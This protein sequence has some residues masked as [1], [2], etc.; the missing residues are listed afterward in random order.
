[1]GSVTFSLQYKGFDYVAFFNGAYEDSNSLASLLQTGANS[2]EA[3][4]D[5]GIDVKT[6]Q[7]VA[8][9]NYTDS[10]TAMGST[11]DQAEGL[12]LSVMVRP[13]IDF[14]NPAVIGPYSVGDWR[15][16]YQPTN[17]SAFFASYKQMI[18]AEAQVAQQHGAQ[19]LSIGAELD[20]L[21]GAQYL[22]YWTDIISSVRAVF[23][24]QLTYS[25]SWNTASNVSFWSQ[26]NY[27][28]I[29]CY[30]PLS[31]AQN[32]TLQDLVNGWIEPATQSANPG[33]YAVIGNQSPIQYFESLAAQSGK[34]LLFT[35][36]GYANDSGAAANPSASG[37]SPDPTLQAELY[38][39]FFQA[40]A[41]SGSSSLIG[42]YFWEWDPNGNTSNVGPGIDSFSP[43]N[44]PAQNEVTAGFET[45][46]GNGHT[47]IVS[48][49]HTLYA[50]TVQSGG[51]EIVNS[52]G[53]AIGSTISSGAFQVIA[54]GGTA[55]DAVMNGAAT[56]SGGSLELTSGAFAGGPVTFAGMSGT[57]RID[58]TAMPS[59]VI[60]GFARGDTIDLAGASFASGGS[61][62]LKS[63][64]VLEVTGNGQTCDLQ[65]DALQKFSGQHFELFMDAG[66]GTD[67]SLVRNTMDDFNG[68]GS[69]DMLWRNTG[70]GQVGIW[71]SNGSGGFTYQ[72]I[73]Q[74]DL[75]WQ[76]VG[77]GSFNGDGIADILWRNTITGQ[78]GLWD[79][80]PSGG[81]TYQ[82]INQGDLTWQV[83][84]IGDFNGDGSAD[85]L[86]RNT[87]TGQVGIWD[88]NGSGGFTYQT[89]NQGDLSW[90]IVGEGDFNGDGSADIL[91]R[92]T[93][94]GQVGIWDS[95]SSGGFTYQ[96]FSEPDLTWQIQGVGDF[97]GDGKS[98][99]LWR[100]SSSGQVGLWE[101]NNS[102]GFTYQI[103]NESDPTWQIEGVG[104]FNGTGQ[105][106]ILWRN[107]TS[108]QIG[109][110]NS[111]GA[112][113]FTY[114]IIP[115]GDPTWNTFNGNDT[116]V[117][118]TAESTLY[119]NPG[120]TTFSIG[121][122]AG[123]DTIYNFQNS[124]DTLQ[125][126]HAL[127]ANFAAAMTSATQVG[128][129][130][131][132]AID[133]NDSVTLES[134]SKSSLAAS[135]FRFG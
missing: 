1:M 126:N 45:V 118:S 20:Q 104:D 16:N 6:S 68:D 114:Q 80:K 47:Q 97:N 61:V 121:P 119:G 48:S 107:S 128:A 51:T 72:T 117:A 134:V 32:P 105:D 57:L 133:A 44:S 52:G 8:D 65:L 94:N 123:K 46:I 91:W 130:T 106:G 111:N 25:A 26:L 37:N 18:V 3:T 9:S 109:I 27:E 93:V 85:I 60:S 82:T 112:G 89:I 67:I 31:N 40:W 11:I 22:S 5:Y 73:N 120:N 100:N 98:D 95:N 41:Q 55:I 79:S 90:Q 59:D 83:Q 88:S 53:T 86:W 42:T 115:E 10:L 56:I 49:G 4:L 129:N 71:N 101:T 34:P 92:D 87:T 12:G 110:W 99:L 81:F 74:G 2:I 75:S 13:L 36:L 108:G 131:V 14:L 17:I 62:Q 43:Q 102:G 135:N 21:A 39:A 124:Q 125:F 96:A 19:M 33:A 15:Q 28:G 132:F 58:G 127:F 7:V 38:Q 69:T 70:T 24:G 64:N 35:E 29:D 113:G 50:T 76:I 78:V 30:V 63:G 103:F 116:L 23:S 66:S 54:S 122:G 84:G 77:V